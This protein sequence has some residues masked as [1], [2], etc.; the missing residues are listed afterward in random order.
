MAT[1]RN[2]KTGT[3]ALQAAE[4]Q[5]QALEM[6]KRGA[7]FDE[8]AKALRYANRASA[9]KAVVAALKATLR[10]PAD[11]VRTMYQERLGLVMASMAPRMLE[12]N[13]QAAM[14]FLKAMAQEAALLGLDAPQKAELT[15]DRERV[16]ERIAAVTG[17]PVDE[18][19][20]VMPSVDGLG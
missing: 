16:A 11:E 6:R 8:I 3:R 2:H 9:H 13:P 18:V 7:T 20:S 4:K 17:M 15:I 10:E 19:I 14:A 5:V 12:G 1:N